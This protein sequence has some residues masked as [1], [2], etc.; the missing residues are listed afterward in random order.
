SSVRKMN[1]LLARLSPGAAR[2][3]DPPRAMAVQPLLE[4]VAAAKQRQHPV[5][6]FAEAGL[7]AMADPNGLEQALT[8]L[9]QNAID[10]SEAD[11]P[12]VLRAFESGG[13]IAIEVIDRGAGMS[14]EFVRTRLFQ[15]F[16][17]TKEQGFGVGAFEAKS[18]IAAMGGRLEVE[19]RPG[20]GTRF[21][22]FL[23]G[24]ESRTSY[25]PERKRA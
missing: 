15:P 11:I 21:T 13:D 10:A 25:V 6:A 3:S 22:L 9:V 24:A 4:A 14:A 12:V 17:S 2:E 16:A 8:H 1:D 23:S 18:L 19:S 7:V 5:R 20:D